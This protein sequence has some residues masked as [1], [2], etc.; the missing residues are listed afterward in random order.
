VPRRQLTIYQNAEGLWW[1]LARAGLAQETRA[2][3]LDEHQLCLLS[4]SPVVCQRS[5]LD[6]VEAESGDAPLEEPGLARTVRL[7]ARQLGRL[8]G[9]RVGAAADEV[10]VLTVADLD[11]LD[12]LAR[13]GRFTPAELRAL[14]QD[15]LRR[16]SAY[17][18]RARVI[19]LGSRSLNHAAQEATH[20]VRAVA[21]GEAGL[22]V[23]RTR[24]EA[25]LARCYDAALGFFGSRLLNP[26]RR[27]L[28]AQEWATAAA[29][30]RAEEHRLAL[31]VVALLAALQPG[32]PRPA[33]PVPATRER[34]LA[35][36]HAFGALLGDAASR[37][38]AQG[39]LDKP[40]VHR[41]F[42][43]PLRVPLDSL[44]ALVRALR[45]RVPQRATRRA[46]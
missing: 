14:R 30:P 15:V 38:F 34:L 36:S 17:I 23:E 45:V 27:S 42:R 41:L 35:A 18:P 2:V 11:G 40:A 19:W 37:A 28:S 21:L 10:E 4:A 20:L 33:L 13:R 39:Q 24:T 8:I 29:D 3:E 43:D 12:R 44:R 22:A 32:G 26:A 31:E 16:E 1:R 7:M 9:V 5:F 46:A 6:Y 25:Y